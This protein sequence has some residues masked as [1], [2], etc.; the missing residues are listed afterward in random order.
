M[1]VLYIGGTG[2]ISA[3]CVW[4]SVEQRQD[5]TVFNR[6][7]AQA[8]L[9]SSVRRI[10]GDLADEAAYAALGEEHFDV[11]C[12]FLAYEMHQVVRDAEVFGGRCGQYVFIS[13]ASA[14][15]KPPTRTVVTEDVPLANP[16][17]PY[18]QRKADMEAFLMARHAEGKLG[19]TVVRPSHTHRTRFPG[20]MAGGDEWAWRMLEG[21]PI[22]VHGDGTS[23]WTLT[24]STDFAVPFVGLLGKAGALG[25]AFHITRH[26]ESH[27]WDHI[28]QAMGAAL[29][30]EPTLVHVPTDTLVRYQPAW[31]G[32]LLGDKTWS[33]IFDNSKVMRVAGDWTCAVSLEEGLRKAAEHYRRDRAPSYQPD[34]AKHEFLDRIAAEQRAL[35]GGD[36]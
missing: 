1:K 5:V 9:P 23:L 20:G 24:Y 28:F 31:A 33:V 7:R 35:G 18:S 4:R 14:Y 16:F 3:A 17:W 32:P 19:V 29:G 25:E 8:D 10:T 27:A 6:G 13:T 2:E 11:V 36:A 26:M 34:P 22:L 12:Q 30:V 15:Q 21:K